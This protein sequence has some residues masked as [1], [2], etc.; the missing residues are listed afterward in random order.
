MI[1]LTEQQ[2]KQLENPAANPPRVVNPRTEET[3]VLLRMDEYER[4]RRE[5]YDDSS[6]T[7]EE[8]EALAWQAAEGSDWDEYDTPQTT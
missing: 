8:L 7:R 2:A 1:K 3:F 5:A 4:L 6:W